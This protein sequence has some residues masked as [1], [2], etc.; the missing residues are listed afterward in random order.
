MAAKAIELAGTQKTQ[1]ALKEIA[2]SLDGISE[3]VLKM[4]GAETLEL[5]KAK[6]PI[7]TGR[8]ASN[9]KMKMLTNKSIELYN[10]LEY[11]RIVEYGSSTQASQ[12]HWRPALEV[13]KQE[14]PKL[15]AKQA[16]EIVEKIAK[17]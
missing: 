14:L 2:A 3:Q 9:H 12:P 5:V 1:A 6:T 4:I 11:A 8:L 17:S 15:Y 16:R 13:A 7:R 10:D